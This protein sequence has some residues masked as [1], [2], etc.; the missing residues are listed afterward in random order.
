[1][2]R[3]E[4]TKDDRHS[5]DPK[6]SVNAASVEKKQ[7]GG[8]HNWGKDGADAAPAALDKGDP[9][10]DSDAEQKKKDGK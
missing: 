6:S 9:N 1:M 4:Q 5:H 8:A 3:P 2:P 7:G 10:Y